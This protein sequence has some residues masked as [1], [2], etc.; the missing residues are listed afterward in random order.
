MIS[1]RIQKSD[2]KARKRGL[3]SPLRGESGVYAFLK[4]DEALYIG[5]SKNLY[6]RLIAHFSKSGIHKALPFDEVVFIFCD[7]HRVLEKRLID[8]F[9][10]EYNGGLTQKIYHG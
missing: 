8:Y 5:R 1:L 3:W 9:D 4:D 7:N 10:P 2:I 6:Q